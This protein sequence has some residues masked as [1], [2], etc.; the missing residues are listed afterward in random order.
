VQPGLADIPFDVVG[1]ECPVD[2]QTISMAEDAGFQWVGMVRD[3]VQQAYSWFHHA[4]APGKFGR[5][6]ETM[7]EWL[8]ACG[9]TGSTCGFFTFVPNLQTRWLAGRRCMSQPEQEGCVEQ[10]LA[11]L[12]RMAVVLEQDGS[13]VKGTEKLQKLGWTVHEKEQDAGY[14]SGSAT[15]LGKAAAVEIAH[16]AE[17]QHLDMRLLKEARAQGLI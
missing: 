15:L 4:R 1:H 6:E 16:V 11:N 10:A 17:L 13:R 2:A 5:T 14:V 7:T 9:G 12:K 8:R 3:P